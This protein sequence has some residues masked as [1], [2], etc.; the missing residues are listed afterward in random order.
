MLEAV[1]VVELWVAVVV[2]AVVVEAVV[3]EAVVAAEAAMMVEPVEVSELK[4]MD[5]LALE[6]SEL[7]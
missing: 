2:E 3:M 5:G 4:E 7:H 1:V 6:T